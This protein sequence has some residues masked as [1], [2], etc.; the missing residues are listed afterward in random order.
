MKTA[1]DKDDFFQTGLEAG[2]PLKTLEFLWTYCY[3]L[4]RELADDY[5]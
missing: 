2:I 1:N 3:A 4:D 5:D